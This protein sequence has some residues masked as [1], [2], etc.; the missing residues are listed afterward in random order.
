MAASVVGRMTERKRR[1]VR[2][3]STAETAQLVRQALAEAFPG[4]TFSV[5]SRVYSG[6][7]S[8]DVHWTD[9]PTRQEVEQVACRFEGATFDGMIDLK[10]HHTSRFR[11][12]EVGFGA[13]FVSCQRT[14]SADLLRMCVEQIAAEYDVPPPEVKVSRSTSASMSHPSSRWQGLQPAQH[15]LGQLLL[16][17]RIAMVGPLDHLN[18]EPRD[19]HRTTAHILDVWA[20]DG[21][22]L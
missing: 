6:G 17:A 12:E 13:D 3:F 10:T 7:S 11:G 18:V 21:I 4:Q 8:V 14:L 1:P 2:R 15:H 20:Q 22:I 19:L 16:V 5:R 9:G